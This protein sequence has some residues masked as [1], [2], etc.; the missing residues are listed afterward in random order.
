[1][2][3]PYI[4][5]MHGDE[6]H[7]ANPGALD[8]ERG[9]RDDLQQLRTHLSEAPGDYLE[10][11]LENAAL[12]PEELMLVL[13]SPASTAD[14]L[15]RIARNRAW[16]RPREMKVAFV[17]HPRAPWVLARRFYPHLYW[18]DLAD[19]AANLRISPVLRREAE[20]LL[21]TRLPELSVG[22]K[23]SL[24]R[25]GSRG[26]VEMLCG[27][28]EP[29]VLRAVVGN[30]RTTEGDIARILARSDLL[31]EFLGW[32]ASQSAWGQRRAVRLA[33]VRHPS[34]PFAAALRSIQALSRGDL[35]DLQHDA[36]AP[37]LAR[38]AAERL[39]A[40]ADSRSADE[41]VRVG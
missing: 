39:L 35:A 31:P 25:R 10:G 18:K 1:V 38:V 29:Q 36:I 32:L 28:P 30:P 16:M 33:L 15:T 12:G 21:K 9:R 6:G 40:E 34:T 3:V 23:V 22:E 27:E 26:I 4:E 2:S 17:A 14:I 20:R 7:S 41:R 24:A 37:R 13:R 5:G 11:A 8:R 19:V